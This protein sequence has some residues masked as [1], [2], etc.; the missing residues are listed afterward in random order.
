MGGNLELLLHL[1][2]L[3]GYTSLP[4][5]LLQT[6]PAPASLQA[7]WA[8]WCAVN[9]WLAAFW[10]HIEEIRKPLFITIY[11]RHRKSA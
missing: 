7:T 2:A 8:H 3:E 1:E 11:P 5:P 10:C 6:L 9:L 4:Q